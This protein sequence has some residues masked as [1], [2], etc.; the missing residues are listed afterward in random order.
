MQAAPALRAAG[1]V[2]PEHSP[3][4]V[5]RDQMYRS[6]YAPQL[7]AMRELPQTDDR[8]ARRPGMPVHRFA[9]SE[10]ANRR[11]IAWYAN[12]G[13]VDLPNWVHFFRSLSPARMWSDSCVSCPRAV[14]RHH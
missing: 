9:P 6:P 10:K 12:N 11:A 14:E 2:R 3:L 7:A 8:G 5:A 1:T 4:N 13:K